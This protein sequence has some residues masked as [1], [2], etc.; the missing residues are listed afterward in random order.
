MRE[1]LF[2]LSEI[3]DR[4]PEPV[5]L[6]SGGMVLYCNDS[7]V[8]LF[9]GLAE[10]GPCP[11]E[12]LELSGGEEAQ[13]V[14]TRKIGKRQWNISAAPFAGGRLV[15]LR[16]ETYAGAKENRIEALTVQIRRQM[17]A[18]VAAVQQLEEIAQ[19]GKDSAGEKWVAILNQ[20]IYRVLR[21][22][23][24]AEFAQLLEDDAQVVCRPAPMDLVGLCQDIEPQVFSLAGLAGRQF[25]YESE[26]TSIITMG[27]VNLLQRMLLFLLSNALKAT[28]VGGRFGVRLKKR[29]G[30]AILTVWD[31]GPG[32]EEAS[33]GALFQKREAAAPFSPGT[34]L[35][36]GLEKV[37]KIAFLHDGTVVVESRKDV[38]VQVTVS[39]P[40]VP[41][42]G[43]PLRAA[44]QEQTNGFSPLLIELSETL[45]WQ[46]FRTS[47]ME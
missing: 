26:E 37:R 19:M 34:G 35:G 28:P 44:R 4:F 41:A 5:I 31:S 14:L 42:E 9:E 36:L 7:A 40:V 20:S 22:V 29:G 45:P 8:H 3:F 32:M 38:G 6:L 30:K 21:A 11:P 47:D 18:L 46:A 2:G 43:L 25:V 33:L 16:P 27:D 23:G 15:V 12:L 10:A 1:D 39:L 24:N 13:R 17:A